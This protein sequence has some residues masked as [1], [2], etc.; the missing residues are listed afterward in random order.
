[1]AMA[2]LTDRLLSYKPTGTTL[3]LLVGGLTLLAAALR[4]YKLDQWSFWI[5]E[6]Y[7]IQDSLTLELSPQ[8][9]AEKFHFLYFVA[10]RPLLEIGRAHV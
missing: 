9:L 4:L 7:S 5:D 6:M 2:K 10:N 3:T 1:M 8:I